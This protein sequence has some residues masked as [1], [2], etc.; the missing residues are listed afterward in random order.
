MLLR[1]FVMLLAASVYTCHAEP[2]TSPLHRLIP[3]DNMTDVADA[4]DC[5]NVALGLDATCWNQIPQGVGMESWL[6]TWNATTKTCKKGEFWANCFMR[7]ANVT[8]NATNPIRC[9]LIGPDVC[10]EPSDDV[11]ANAS[12]EVAYGVTAIWGEQNAKPK[13]R[14]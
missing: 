1:F 7:E 13:L 4:V 10:P 5:Q 8:N 6:N 9:D 11:F 12:A 14:T 3:R 2:L